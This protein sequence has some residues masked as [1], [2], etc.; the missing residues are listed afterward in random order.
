MLKTN[1]Y[2]FLLEQIIYSKNILRPPLL[3]Q[4]YKRL[5]KN[6]VEENTTHPKKVMEKKFQYFQSMLTCALRNIDKGNISREVMKKMIKTLVKN[7]LMKDQKMVDTV[8]KKYGEVPSFIVLSPT[9]VCNLKCTGCYAAV[10]GKKFNT[11]PYDVV[12]KIIGECHSWGNRFMT[13]SG[14]EPLMYKSQARLEFS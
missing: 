14:G 3:K 9:G 11:L 4:L 5:H 12:D 13:I 8:K 7:A 2:T 6:L 10:G 1:V